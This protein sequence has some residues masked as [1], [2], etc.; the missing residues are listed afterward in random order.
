MKETLKKCWIVEHVQF[1]LQVKHVIEL[2][3]N[4]FIITNFLSPLNTET[5]KE[6]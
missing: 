4:Y 2:T 1:S 5:G 3:I 6:T